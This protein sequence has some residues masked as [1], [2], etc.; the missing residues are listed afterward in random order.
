M[1][2]FCG[3]RSRKLSGRISSSAGSQLSNCTLVLDQ[4]A[5]ER[6]SETGCSFHSSANEFLFKLDRVQSGALLQGSLASV[7]A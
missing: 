3:E 2:A 4:L 5:S 7:V 1:I 6:L